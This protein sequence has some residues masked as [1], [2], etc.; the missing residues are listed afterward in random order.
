[1]GDIARSYAA[2]AIQAQPRLASAADDRLVEDRARSRLAEQQAQYARTYGQRCAN[3][4]INMERYIQEATVRGDEEHRLQHY[5][6]LLARD[7]ETL[8]RAQEEVLRATEA[9]S[10]FQY[11]VDQ[12]EAAAQPLIEEMS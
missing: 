4:V 10:G 6:N 7:Q 1:M 9:A 8:E 3:Q 12:L 2:S 5:A 11:E